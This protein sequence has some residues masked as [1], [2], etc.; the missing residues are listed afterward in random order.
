MMF[1]FSCIDVASIAFIALIL[2]GEGVA[3]P[4]GLFGNMLEELSLVV[5]HQLQMEELVMLHQLQMEELLL[6]PLC[7]VAVPLLLLFADR[8]EECRTT[9]LVGSLD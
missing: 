5:L 6:S 8:M 4:W 7:R 2:S 9:L 1:I 3:V